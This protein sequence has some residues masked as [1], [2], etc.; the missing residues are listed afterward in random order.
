MNK[1]FR[2]SLVAAALTLPA[3]T[4]FAGTATQL[5]QRDIHQEQR[6][7]QGLRNESLTSGEAAQLQRGAAYI[8]QLQS[9][10]LADGHLSRDEAARIE[11]AQDQQ[12]RSITQQMNDRQ[13]G[14]ANSQ[15]SR[16][17]QANVARDIDQERRILAGQRDGS[18]SAHETSRLEYGQAASG[19]QTAQAQASGHGI[20]PWEQQWLQRGDAYNSRQIAEERHDGQVRYDD[21]RDDD[22]HAWWSSNRW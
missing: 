2:L 6:I 21:R 18:L 17:M 14:Y 5:Q 9:Q 4:A 11:R 7:E 20:N 8:D 1:S 12:A 10:A 13:Y 15:Q 22:D 3:F 19:W 16:Y